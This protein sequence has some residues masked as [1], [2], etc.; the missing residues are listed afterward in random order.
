M[1]NYTVNEISS[2]VYQIKDPLDVLMYLIV[3]DEKTLLFD[4]GYGII[5]TPA[6]VKSITDKPLTVVLGHGH[7]DHANGAYQFGEV[8]L[9]EPDYDLF[10]MH[11]SADIRGTILSR[12]DD[13]GIEVD[14]DKE[15]WISL[16]ACQ[17]KPLEIGAVFDLG[18]INVEVVD[19][20]GHTGGSIG[21]LLL[22]KRILI[23][24]DSA[25]S[26]C[27]MFVPE[28]LSVREY[29]A[30]LERVIQLDFDTFYV[31]HQEYAHTKEDMKKFINVA[32]NAT[33]EKSEP[34]D[35]WP[36]FKPYIY[37]QGDVSIVINERTLV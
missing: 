29:I 31:A 13:A 10:R 21:I 23:D 20:A 34:Y 37:T 9:R 22:E 26:H 30:M 17:L 36:E 27:W 6:M 35:N 15:T 24:S 3:G 7:I 25:N 14:F 18:G 11:T 28:S 12:L 5:D 32:K 4:T 1:L 2:G 33:I 19:M 8:Y 16:G